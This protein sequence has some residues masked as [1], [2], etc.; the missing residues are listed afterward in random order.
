MGTYNGAKYSDSEID[1]QLIASSSIINMEERE[2]ALQAIN[3][4][5]VDDV[6][7]IPLHYQQDLAAVVK[8]KGIKFQPRPDRWVVL[9]EIQ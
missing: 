9:K 1:S 7:W 2:K 5:S 8:G 3:K 4:K 6:A